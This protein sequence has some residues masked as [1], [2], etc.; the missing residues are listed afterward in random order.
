MP[1]TDARSP[2]RQASW[3]PADYETAARLVA[4][5]FAQVDMSEKR[6]FHPV[7]V[8]F[9]ALIDRDPVVRMA[10]TAMIDQIPSRY[11]EHHPKTVNQLLAQLNAVLSIAP[12]YIPLNEP[13]ETVALVGTPFSAVLIWTMGTPAGFAAYRDPQINAMFKQLLK[14]WARFLDSE[15]ST[16]VINPSATGWQCEAAQ[17][18]LQMDDYQYAPD[19]HHWG[20][21]SWNAFFTRK[22][23]EGKRPIQ[24]PEDSSAIVAACD[25]KVYRIARNVARQ[26]KF[27]IKAQPYSLEDMLDHQHVDEFVGGDV[28]QAFLNPFNYHRWHSPVTGTI[29]QA[30][31]KD[32]LYFSQ[33]PSEGEDWTDQN[34]S[35]AYI[36][37]VQ[38]RA[39]IFI[40]A[41]NPAIGLVCVMPIGMVEISSCIIDDKIK[42]GARV[43][44]GQEMGYFQFGGSTHCLLFRKGVI[45]AF[46]GQENS[47]YQVGQIVAYANS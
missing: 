4:T 21:A 43:E 37:H 42:P 5:L 14:V 28:F 8:A 2:A 38:T 47:P 39:I 27:W 32:G 15:A 20:F 24:S 22:L 19:A 17:A 30:F 12:A 3:L 9:K 35:E 26:E 16:Y 33:A 25:S 29:R 13:K 31:V 45:K 1:D 40:E 10:M 7:I 18:Q 6:V 34:H 46:T 23:K 11:K 41:D 36:A 44:K